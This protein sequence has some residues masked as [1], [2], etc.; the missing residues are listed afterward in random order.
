FILGDDSIGRNLLDGG[1]GRDELRL[2]GQN[3]N[4]QVLLSTVVDVDTDVLNTVRFEFIDA[5]GDNNTLMVGDDPNL[6]AAR[7]AWTID[8]DNGGY[9]NNNSVTF[10]GFANLRGDAR[11]DTYEF[12]LGGSLTGYIDGGNQDSEDVVD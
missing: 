8:A 3:G 4:I 7:T 11:N 1:A 10:S 6:A 5:A 9:F 12:L 2:T